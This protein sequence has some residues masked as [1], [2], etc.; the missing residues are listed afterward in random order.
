MGGSSI[1]TSDAG[2][3]MKLICMHEE[4][5]GSLIVFLTCVMEDVGMPI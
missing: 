4:V 2:V 3:E 5:N 1:F